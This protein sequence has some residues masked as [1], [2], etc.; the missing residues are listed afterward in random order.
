MKYF[1]GFQ[2]K[3]ALYIEQ[4]SDNNELLVSQINQELVK[5]GFILA[6]STL[7]AMTTL[8]IK[9]LEM[10]YNDLI[11]NIKDI[12]PNGDDYT[13]LHAGFPDSVQGLGEQERL[14]I[15]LLHYATEGTWVP[16]EAEFVAQQT[17]ATIDLNELKPIGLLNKKQ[18]IG[19]VNNILASGT[20]LSAFDTGIVNWFLDNDYPIDVDS[21]KF[22]ETLA[23]VG[24]NLLERGMKITTRKADNILRIWS[25]YSGGDVGLK[26]NVKFKS[27]TNSQRRM[28]LETLNDCYDLEESFKSNREKWL[29][30]L[31]YLHPMTST[32]TI[33][34]PAVA[35]YATK[36]RNTP[37]LLKTF[38]SKVESAIANKDKGIFELL[39]KRMGVFTRRLDHLV[40]VFGASAVT[41]WVANKPNT[42]QLITMY[43]H[44]HGRDK[45]TSRSAVLAGAGTSEVVTYGSVVALPKKVVDAGRKTILD[46]LTKNLK[47]TLTKVYIDEALYR[48]PLAINNR[49]ASVGITSA[50]TGSVLPLNPIKDIFRLYC[51]WSNGPGRVDI[52]FSAW[53]V[54]G[55]DYTK[56]GYG[57][58]NNAPGITYSGDNTGS[59]AKNSEYL[60]IDINDLD[61]KV[62]WVVSEAVIYAGGTSF[63]TLP[64]VFTGCM[65]ISKAN[66]SMTKA[67]I[68]QNVTTA[69]KLT[70]DTSN[71]YLCAL[72]VPTKSIVYLD[73]SKA[74]HHVS[75]L[76]EIKGFMPF[77]EKFTPNSGAGI[78]WDLLNQGQ[79]LNLMA[80]EVVETPEEALYVFAEDVPSEEVT[81]LL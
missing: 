20:S 23:V 59:Y 62:E 40:R 77:L 5:L 10:L 74:G 4:G 33:K 65:E 76:D 79:L 26:E 15:A 3:K 29:K 7:E 78:N 42:D 24:V 60:D 63:T 81:A 38:N 71:A 80:D 64:P 13:P 52:D 57:G 75:G 54:G 41:K 12:M 34:Y 1:I 19:I 37:K 25:G 58:Q 56:V 43:N 61:P 30:V 51:H 32:N 72:H 69:I 28:L 14:H 66:S 55:G 49:A 68:P 46:T 35:H 9:E 2:K 48:R 53:A 11:Y 17:E 67:W 27:P 18:F 39:S 44:L 8:S 22:N 16:E 70:S 50:N 47:G 45:V 6:K 31:Y 36:L 21:I 73:V